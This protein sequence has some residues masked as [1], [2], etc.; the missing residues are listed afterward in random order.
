MVARAHRQI[1]RHGDHQPATPPS[2]HIPGKKRSPQPIHRDACGLHQ[3]FIAKPTQGGGFNWFT[4]YN[5]GI[6][7]NPSPINRHRDCQQGALLPRASRPCLRAAGRRHVH[8]E[9][10]TA[11]CPTCIKPRLGRPRPANRLCYAFGAAGGRWADDVGKHRK[12][13]AKLE[14]REV[15]QQ[16]SEQEESP[17]MR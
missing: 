2:L 4:E 7:L 12:R 15:E 8:P 17:S 16:Q 10:V 11:K 1:G 5:E 9:C 14:C 6:K 3:T 13:W